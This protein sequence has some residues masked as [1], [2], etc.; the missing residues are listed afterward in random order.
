MF[1]YKIP[2]GIVGGDGTIKQFIQIMVFFLLIME[3]DNLS[4]NTTSQE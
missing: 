1:I 3:V 2:G 4:T